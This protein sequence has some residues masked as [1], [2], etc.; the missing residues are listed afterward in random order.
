MY[1]FPQPYLYHQIYTYCEAR[2]IHSFGR[3]MI[4]IEIFVSAEFYVEIVL[5][6]RGYI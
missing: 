1:V 4:F 3:S 6:I 5:D 2:I